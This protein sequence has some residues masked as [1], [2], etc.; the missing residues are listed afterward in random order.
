MGLAGLALKGVG[1]VLVLLVVVGGLPAVDDVLGDE[2]LVFLGLLGIQAVEDTDAELDVVQ[3]LVATCLAE[4]LTDDN[5]K[6]LQ[7]V[8]L[9]GHG[10]SW[11]NPGALAK[12]VGNGE[13]IVVL[14]ELLVD[15]ESYE[16]E[17]IATGLGHDDETQLLKGLGQVVRSTGEVG[18]DGAV[19]VL[20]ETDE[21]VVLT[22]DLGGTLG[23]VKSE[24]GLVSTK[25]IDVEDKLLRKVLYNISHWIPLCQGTALPLPNARYTIQHLGI[26][27]LRQS[28]KPQN[29]T[30]T[31]LLTVLVTGSVDRDDLL[32]SE[33]P[34]KL[35]NNK[36]SHETT[37]SGINVDDGVNVSLDQ[38]IVNGLGIFVLSSVGST[39]NN[40]DTNG[41]LINQVDSL[42]GIDDVSVGGAVDVLLLNIKVSGG[43]LPAHLYGRRHDNVWVLGGLALGSS[44]V[45]PALLHGKD[46]KHN[47]LGA[48]N[49]AGA[50]GTLAV[51][52]S[53][54][55]EES[56]D[57]V[58]TSVLN[59]GALGVF[60]VVDEV[61][62]KGLGHE[63][64]DLFLLRYVSKGA[65]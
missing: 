13:L 43:L 52:V 18:H 60:F 22:D 45:L 1:L 57:H 25:V 48:T 16:R 2:V 17:T 35:R 27:D 4:V 8:R 6:H 28:E 24:R 26:R 47:S 14:V 3:E 30:P 7:V 63:I 49:G 65:R 41:V 36:W 62:G 39:E 21:L 54:G 55:I 38:E 50:D 51:I 58:D 29:S 59:V 61:L 34:L 9:G 20:A 37:G 10:V 33:I 56:T 42:L 53:W 15:A 40:T 19:S 31:T 46:T 44:L 11:D 12:L 5:A 64:L 23:E 32:K